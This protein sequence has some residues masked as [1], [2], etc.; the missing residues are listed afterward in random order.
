LKY[1]KKGK[2]VESDYIFINASAKFIFIKKLFNI[3][4]LKIIDEKKIKKKK[5][6]VLFT[7]YFLDLKKYNNEVTLDINSNRYGVIRV[8]LT[9]NSYYI[10]NIMPLIF[11]YYKNLII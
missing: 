7:I 10:K 1:G 9:I 11:F 6:T 4:N 8:F 5:Y 3:L 2:I